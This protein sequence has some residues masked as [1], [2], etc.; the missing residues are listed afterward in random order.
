V[1]LSLHEEN[2]AMSK[3]LKIII[4]LLVVLIIGVLVIG[5]LGYILFS[6]KAGDTEMVFAPT[7]VGTPE[8]PNVTKNIGP[9][10]GTLAS[11][12]G[13]LTLTVPQNALTETVGFSI[14]PITNKAEGGIG[15]GYR[16]E[17]NGKTFT[18]PLEISVRY[19]DKDLEGT[20]PEALAIGYQDEQKAWHLLNAAK[21][22]QSGK[23][24]TVSA[25]HFTDWSFLKRLRIS[26]EKAT[27]RV[28]KT[29]NLQMTG[30]LPEDKVDWLTKLLRKSGS[31]CDT[32]DGRYRWALPADWY[33]DEGTIDDPHRLRILY[34]A[35]P[36]K[37][38]PNLATVSYPYFLSGTEGGHRGMFT[39]HITIID[40]GY[41]ASGHDGTTSYHGVVCSLEQPFTIMGDNTLVP[42]PIKFFPTSGTGG[43][44]SYLAT[45]K[46]LVMSGVGT[47]TVEGADT[48]NP[49]ILAQTKSTLT[50][51]GRSSSG[52][53]PAHIDLTP[54]DTNECGDQ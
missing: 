8:G 27:V 11:P 36:K 15:L 50:G 1:F 23:T 9:A 3:S 7:E 41:R 16:L 42:Y 30:C 47:Y 54:L 12:D 22:D 21:L 32:T 14:Q 44:L 13:R 46:V 2:P 10:G 29:L 45:W 19:D 51:M 28:G 4:A 34:T 52:G 24:L 33:V 6:R 18:T 40:R 35:P 20:I 17:P 25:T 38:S 26:P 48:D 5:A 31:Q 37:P 39:A 43:T 49:W 53:G